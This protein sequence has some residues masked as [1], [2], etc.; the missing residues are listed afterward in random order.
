[1]DHSFFEVGGDSALMVRVQNKLTA[2][3][4]K[5][6]PMSAMFNH[7]TVPA[8]AAFLDQQNGGR[9]LFDSIDERAKRQKDALH[10]QKARF[11]VAGVLQREVPMIRGK[12]NEPEL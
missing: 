10:R 4:K 8:L 9:S 3:L 6:I 11:R 2:V 5:D 12:Q 7:P 1:M